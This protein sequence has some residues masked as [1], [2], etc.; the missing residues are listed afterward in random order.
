MSSLLQRAHQAL[1]ELGLLDA[2]APTPPEGMELPQLLE[3]LRLG[4]ADRA[5]ALARLLADR[6]LSALLAQRA[7]DAAS[8]LRLARGGGS[9]VDEL[10]A[11]PS[12]S[13]LVS[14][15]EP[16]ACPEC[17]ARLDLDPELH[18]YVPSCPACGARCA[19]RGGAARVAIERVE[20]TWGGW[21]D[22]D[23]PLDA[24]H[25][26]EPEGTLWA[27][28]APGSARPAHQGQ[29]ETLAPGAAPTYQ[30][31]DETLAPGAEPTYQ[32]LDETLAPGAAP[33]Y[34]GLDETLAPG[35]EPT[36]QGLDETLAP[37]AEPTYQGLDDTPGLEP[38]P[39]NQGL[40][41]AR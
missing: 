40:D 15:R 8:E 37:G 27:T 39:D 7:E 23:A 28:L 14:A 17:P 31:L 12:Q 33:T 22:D 41:Q 18:A 9:A 10:P 13:T 35:A 19:E 21:S 25:G 30:G 34:Q 32:G 3:S 6:G 26:P 29:D 5:R 1:R 24:Q 11:P 4:R 36:Y 38:E 16:W 2:A 20:A